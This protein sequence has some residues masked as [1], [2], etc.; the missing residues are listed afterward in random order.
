[1]KLPSS[2]LEMIQFVKDRLPVC[3]VGTLRSYLRIISHNETY[4]PLTDTFFCVHSKKVMHGPFEY[5]NPAQVE[6]GLRILFLEIRDYELA[7]DVRGKITV[8]GTNAHMYKCLMIAAFVLAMFIAGLERLLPY[9]V[10]ATAAPVVVPVPSTPPADCL[11]SSSNGPCI[12]FNTI[13]QQMQKS[14]TPDTILANP[15]ADD[16]EKI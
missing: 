16:E 12:P 11:P 6:E 5:T 13:I 15:T 2:E 4:I 14:E 9:D 7:S 8:P 1:M 10:P 3:Q